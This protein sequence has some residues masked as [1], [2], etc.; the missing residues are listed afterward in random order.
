MAPPVLLYTLVQ[1]D[2]LGLKTY[3]EFL[4]NL[5]F[6]E[7]RHLNENPVSQH[8]TC[9]LIECELALVMLHYK[10]FVLQIYFVADGH[11]CY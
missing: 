9:F 8:C 4:L 7:F 2:K 5:T 1:T 3:S 6:V 10:L 11:F